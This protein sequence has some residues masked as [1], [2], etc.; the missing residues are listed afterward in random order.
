VATAN[1]VRVVEIDDLIPRLYQDQIEAETS[2]ERMAWFFNRESAR[3][4][5][6]AESYGGFS[7]VAF[8]FNDPNLATPTPLTALLLPLLFAY[9][10][11][12]G[13]PFKSLLRIRIGL[14][15]QNPGG[16]PYHNPHVDFYMPHQN[17]LYYVND[18]DGDTF[19]FNETYDEVSLERSLEYTRDRKFTIA[20]QTSPKKGRMIGFDGKQYHASMHPK[21]S[22]HR[23]A[24]AFSFV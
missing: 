21:Q 5:E 19:V 24:I 12:A 1:G 23:I 17:A 6:V 7:H 4:V 2:S 14:F 18:S 13:V 20:R 15:T 3:R 10:D 8:R 22:S 11:R 16:G 9:C